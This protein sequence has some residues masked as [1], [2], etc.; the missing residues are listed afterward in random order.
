M[1]ALNEPNTN[2]D[3]A[4]LTAFGKSYEDIE[5][6]LLAYWGKGAFSYLTYDLNGRMPDFKIT[7][8]E[9]S[10][11]EADIQHDEARHLTGNRAK[12][13][14]QARKSFEKALKAGIRPD[15]MR[16]YLAELALHGNN[17]DQANIYATD[18]L[19]NNPAYAPALQIQSRAFI[20]GKD[21]LKLQGDELTEY[22]SLVTTALKADKYYVPALLDYAQL[23]LYD[24]IE[25]TP[26]TLEIAEL[27][28]KL[29]PDNFNAKTT[30]ISLLWKNGN[31]EKARR[32]AQLLI[33][34][35]ASEDAKKQYQEYYKPLFN[36]DTIK[37]TPD[38]G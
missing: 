25:I 31:L 27:A 6:E 1:R 16:I 9:M 28:R 10:Q 15:D 34:W 17:P 3:T 12:K 18:I 21:P 20:H 14:K 33:D 8:R 22:R 38:N 23:Y 32:E 37:H 7:I 29:A 5:R 4:F 13:F 11:T 36:P 2:D 30:H 35:A 24:G 26:N 19:K